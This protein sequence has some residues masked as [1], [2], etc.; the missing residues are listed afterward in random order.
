MFVVATL[1]HSQKL[2]IVAPGGVDYSQQACPCS[3]EER[4]SRMC[5]KQ[6]QR[7]DLC[8]GSG[9]IRE[10]IQLIRDDVARG[11]RDAPWTDSV[12]LPPP[13]KAGWNERETVVPEELHAF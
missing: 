10:S 13:G 12:R 8:L 7:V 9:K 3:S 2:N 6:I 1:W 4:G 5:G 11:S